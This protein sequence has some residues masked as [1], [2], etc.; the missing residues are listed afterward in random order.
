MPKVELHVHVDPEHFE[1]YR[2]EARRRGVTV[3]SLI[4]QT[5]E[6]MLGE[7]ER[8]ESEGTDHPIIPG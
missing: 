3:E 8:E 6:G 4:E 7:L 5:V 1:A 2:S